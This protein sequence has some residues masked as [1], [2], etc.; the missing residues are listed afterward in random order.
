MELKRCQCVA[1][2]YLVL[3]KVQRW[4]VN[5]TTNVRI[6]WEVGNVLTSWT[7]VS[8][9]R[10]TLFPELNVCA[11]HAGIVAI[12]HSFEKEP[13]DM[14]TRITSWTRL[15]PPIG[16]HTPCTQA[17]TSEANNIL[18]FKLSDK[19]QPLRHNKHYTTVMFYYKIPRE[20]ITVHTPIY[21]E[22]KWNNFNNTC[23]IY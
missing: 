8:L 5:T 22:R 17:V 15:L 1:W 12:F 3:Y 11:R 21:Y 9:L 14:E 2:I 20:F 6:P 7:T 4:A 16:V 23:S 18:R 10:T 19:Q 13:W